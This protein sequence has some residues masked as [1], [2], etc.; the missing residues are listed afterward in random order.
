MCS[1]DLKSNST[2]F[3]TQVNLGAS[4]KGKSKLDFYQ[5]SSNEY[6]W[7]ENLYRAVINK[8]PSHLKASAT[9]GSRFSYTFPPYSITCVEVS[10]AH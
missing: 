3:N 8:G 10:A 6:Q 2:A 7:S 4:A 5:L 9:V 1:S